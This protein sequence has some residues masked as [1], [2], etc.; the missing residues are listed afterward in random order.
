ML[1]LLIAPMPLGLRPC[2][3]LGVGSLGGEQGR[4]I[5]LDN[6]LS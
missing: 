2:L 5:M 3:L 6:K 4:Q 1:R